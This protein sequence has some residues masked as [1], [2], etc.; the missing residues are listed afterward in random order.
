MVAAI[1]ARYRGGRG[2]WPTPPSR[3]RVRAVLTMPTLAPRR[4]HGRR[5]RLRDAPPPPPARPRRDVRG[6]ATVSSHPKNYCR[7]LIDG[8]YG[9][10]GG[11]VKRAPPGAPRAGPR[12]GPGAGARRGGASGGGRA[13]RS[14]TRAIGFPPCAGRP[15]LDPVPVVPRHPYLCARIP[16][17]AGRDTRG[18]DSYRSG[19][20]SAAW[21][22]TGTLSWL[23]PAPPPHEQPFPPPTGVSR[24]VVPA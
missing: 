6:A 4:R 9:Q 13:A 8:V 5:H 1:G 23:A 19:A 21:R 3:R 2:R 14:R 11:G 16:V 18:C 15:P 17:L 24:S 22:P 12:A 20:A 10:G 7:D